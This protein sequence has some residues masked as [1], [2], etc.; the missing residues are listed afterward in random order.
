MGVVAVAVTDLMLESRIAGAAR[1][2]G[3]EPRAV[4]P[5]GALPEALEGA[6]VVVVDLQAQGLD[7]MATVRAAVASGARVIAFG[8]HTKADA[9][10]E[11]R[12]AG[13]EA[14][15]RSAFFERLPALLTQAAEPRATAR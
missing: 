4:S 15:P 13:A 14:L 9:L 7:P 8:Q 11:A 1:R 12:D 2:C 6:D 5:H 10:R 3:L